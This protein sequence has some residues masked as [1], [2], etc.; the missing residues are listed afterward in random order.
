MGC[1]WILWISMF[2][3]LINANKSSF[4][5]Y[6]IDTLLCFSDWDLQYNTKEKEFSCTPA[7]FYSSF[8]RLSPV[9]W[10]FPSVF[11]PFSISLSESLL[12]EN[13]LRFCLSKK[14]PYFHFLPDRH[15]C[16]AQCPSLPGVV[17][18]YIEDHLNHLLIFTFDL[19]WSKK[20]L[21]GRR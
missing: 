1:L 19:E 5:P 20:G 17:F 21:A 10:V 8:L 6:K 18:Q 13:F 15:S 12:V 3:V 7:V 4:Q 2:T 9:H 11:L 16:R 14:W